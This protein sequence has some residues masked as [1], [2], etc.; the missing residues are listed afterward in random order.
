[1]LAHDKH[2]YPDDFVSTIEPNKLLRDIGIPLNPAVTE[3]EFQRMILRSQTLSEKEKAA[4]ASSV[5]LA[6]V[7]ER[8]FQS[9]WR[10]DGMSGSCFDAMLQ[11]NIQDLRRLLH[12]DASRVQGVHSSEVLEDLWQLQEGSQ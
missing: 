5:S 6:T 7:Q 3:A 11:L 2:G 4:L 9:Y 10:L 8:T 1:M 12:P